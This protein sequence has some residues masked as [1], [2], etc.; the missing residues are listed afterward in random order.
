MS[1]ETAS[2]DLHTDRFVRS[3]LLGTHVVTPGRIL[4]WHPLNRTVVDADET[5]AEII[6]SFESPQTVPELATRFELPLELAR[7]LVG[8]L[9]DALV[10]H[11]DGLDEAMWIR[12]KHAATLGAPPTPCM[13]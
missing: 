1:P 4:L 9:R 13:P 11:P 2:P 10:L 12:H 6:A 5:V 7:E 3:G 8:N